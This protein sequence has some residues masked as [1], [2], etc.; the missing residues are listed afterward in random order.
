MNV[1][2]CETFLLE[3]ITFTM[4]MA[5]QLKVCQALRFTTRLFDLETVTSQHSSFTF[6]CF[7]AITKGHLTAEMDLKSF[8]S[9]K[10]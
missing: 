8:G 3:W 5:T 6:A 7:S 1:L 4:D 2:G 9:Q 10:I